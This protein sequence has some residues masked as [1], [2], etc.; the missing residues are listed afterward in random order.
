MASTM[1]KSYV[2]LIV[3]CIIMTLI[4]NSSQV[5]E[6]GNTTSEEKKNSAVKQGLVYQLVAKVVAD[7]K[8]RRE[9]L[10]SKKA[11]ETKEHDDAEAGLFVR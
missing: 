2:I 1:F 5:R 11:K 6:T 10:K 7:D 8:A 3:L 9:K 4:H